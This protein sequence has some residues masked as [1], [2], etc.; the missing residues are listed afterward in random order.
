MMTTPVTFMG[1]TYDPGLKTI[2]LREDVDVHTLWEVTEEAFHHLNLV[3]YKVPIF[4]VALFDQMYYICSWIVVGG[5]VL[6]TDDNRFVPGLLQYL[7]EY[8][9]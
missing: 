2:I 8:A 6:E 1:I 5:E 3:N 4:R 9:E 7:E